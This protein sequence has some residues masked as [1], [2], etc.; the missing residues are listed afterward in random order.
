MV[1]NIQGKDVLGKQLIQQQ[2][3]QALMNSNRMQKANPYSNM[4]IFDQ[5]EISNEAIE[6][7][8]KDNE[9]EYFTN[10]AKSEPD[11]DVDKVAHFK[12]LFESGQYKMPTDDQLAESLLSNSD[13]KVLM[14]F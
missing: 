6:L 7:F 2:E 14:G 11:V 4:P 10:I 1:E 8:E 12:A 5:T 13:F 3:L 9:V